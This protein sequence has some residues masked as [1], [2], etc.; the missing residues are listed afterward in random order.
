MAI[1]M[2]SGYAAQRGSASAKKVE[3]RVSMMI[4]REDQRNPS[5]HRRIR[6]VL[7][8]AG[9]ETRLLVCQIERATAARV[10][11]GGVHSWCASASLG[12]LL[13]L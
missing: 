7:S 6:R 12:L 11:P 2:V 10:S 13:V 8:G 4:C 5:P 9:S 1:D 3:I